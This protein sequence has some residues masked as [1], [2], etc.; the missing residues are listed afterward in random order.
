MSGCGKKYTALA[1]LALILGTFG[2]PSRSERPSATGDV[3][4]LKVYAQTGKGPVRLLPGRAYRLLRP[5]DFA[6]EF[7]VEGTGPRFVRIEV[8]AEG[9]RSVMYEEKLIAPYGEY[10]DY[11]LRLDEGVPDAAVLTVVV[12]AP[13]ML[14]AVS[15]FPVVLVG[16]ETPFWETGTATAAPSR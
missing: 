6:F 15:D 11:V 1:A 16:A 2:C 4:V 8:E 5:Q 14:S 7:E 10:L 12:E 9:V 13:H 3:G